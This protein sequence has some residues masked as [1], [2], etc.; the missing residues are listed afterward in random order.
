MP[1][2]AERWGFRRTTELRRVTFQVCSGS[3]VFHIKKIKFIPSQS[4][5]YITVQGQIKILYL[6]QNKPFQ[7]VIK[8][9]ERNRKLQSEYNGIKLQVRS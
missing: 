7:R 8:H 2:D 5:T 9:K 1:M 6:T 4:V 3:I